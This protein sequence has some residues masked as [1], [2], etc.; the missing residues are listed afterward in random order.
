[1]AAGVDGGVTVVAA[2]LFFH[3][4]VFVACA[5]GEEDEIGPAEGIGGFAKDAAGENMLVAERVLSVNKEKIKAVSEAEVLKAVVEKEGVGLV[6]ADGVAGGFDAVG[7][8]ED[9]DAGKVAC[10]HERFVP[11]LSGIEENRFSVGDNSGRRGSAAGEELVGQACE[12]GFGDAFISA[13]KDGDASARFLKGSGEFFDD[14]CFACASDGEVTDAD[15]HHTDRV[16]AEDGVLVE[17]STY[18]HDACVNGRE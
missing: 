4:G 8:D 2:D 16:A 1:M 6:V 7:V 15:N 14:G 18:A 17:A 3:L 5:F 13:A 11:G 9:G 12:E 10:E